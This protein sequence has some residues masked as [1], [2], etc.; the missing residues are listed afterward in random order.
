MHALIIEDE[1]FIATG[2]EDLLRGLGFASF[3]HASSPQEAIDAA[4]RRCPDLI[5]SDVE[6]RP[7]CGI[8]TVIEI[9]KGA[10]MPVIFITGNGG[11]VHHRLPESRVLEKPFS[12]AQLSAAVQAALSF[13]A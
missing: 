5:T 4:A 1:P 8:S 7:G 2:I 9:C 11:D 10:A 3:D 13:K 6:L 12:S